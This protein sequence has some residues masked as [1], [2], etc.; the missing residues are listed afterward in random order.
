LFSLIVEPRL[1]MMM[2]VVEMMMLIEHEWRVWR[3]V[4]WGGSKERILR[5]EEDR[6][7]LRIY[8]WRQHNETHH[9][10]KEGERQTGR[11]GI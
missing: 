2:V 3:S 10:L 6:S 7:M 4:E 8:L 5:G 11:M 1:K 9:M